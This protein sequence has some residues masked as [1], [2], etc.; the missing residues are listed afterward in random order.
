MENL[1]ISIPKRWLDI[2]HLVG[3]SEL[4]LPY[5]WRLAEQCLTPHHQST[6]GSSG[7]Q[8]SRPYSQD[9]CYCAN[10]R[11]DDD[12]S[13]SFRL[14]LIG[15]HFRQNARSF[16]KNYWASDCVYYN[17]YRITI[18]RGMIPFERL[19][20]RPERVHKFLPIFVFSSDLPQAKWYA[21]ACAQLFIQHYCE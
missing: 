21:C 20:K 14:Q 3:V 2:Y 11:K 17:K 12:N 5:N 7:K 18:I 13:D 9:T 1:C 16:D 8:E 15:A 19:V 10:D 4:I 6:P